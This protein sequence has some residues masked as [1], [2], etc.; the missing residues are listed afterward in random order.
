M[1][2][3]PIPKG[4]PNWD[5]PL[6]A[7]LSVLDN[8]IAANNNNAL[9]AANNLSDL[10]SAAQ[11]RLNLGI[12]SGSAAGV[13]QFNVKD[14]GAIGNGVADDRVPIQNAMAAATAAGGAVVFFP[15]GT[16]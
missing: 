8:T 6:N 10:T 1:T 3:S 13:S 16:Y 11:A 2:Y 12:S 5:V 14:Y 7:A 15:H 4:T 9:Q